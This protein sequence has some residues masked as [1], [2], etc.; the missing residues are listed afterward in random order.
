VKKSV[1]GEGK[2]MS[3]IFENSVVYV[4]VSLLF[5]LAVV[6]TLVGGG[7]LPTFSPTAVPEQP[8]SEIMLMS[9][10]RSAIGSYTGTPLPP[11]DPD[12]Q[13]RYAG[14]PLP[15]PDPDQ[16]LR[17]AGTPLPPPDPDQHLRYAGTPL[18]PPDPDQQLRCA[19]TPLPPPDPDQH[20]RYAGTPLPPPDPDILLT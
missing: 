7:S 13:L 10:I 19:G 11:P 17:Y 15:P 9:S 16:Q 14:T 18:P 4:T 20:L 5:A 8:A 12:Q 6:A 3:R 2:A 1:N